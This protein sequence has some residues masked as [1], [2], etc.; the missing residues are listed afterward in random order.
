MDVIFY[1]THCPKCKVV[2]ILLGKKGIKYV[3]DNDTQHM[4]DIGL[5]SAPGLSVD[6]K[7]ME[8]GEAVAWLKGL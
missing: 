8:F 2:E 3:E 5:T 7:L 6:G 1:S 4:L